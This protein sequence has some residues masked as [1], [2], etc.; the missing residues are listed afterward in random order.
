MKCPEE[1][2]KETYKN[3]QTKK[4]NLNSLYYSG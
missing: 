4:K 2:N 1:D 3:K